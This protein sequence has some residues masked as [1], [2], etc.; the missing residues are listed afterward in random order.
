MSARKTGCSFDNQ[1]SAEGEALGLKWERIDFDAKTIRIE[2]QGAL[3]AS[4]YTL[5]RL[6]LTDS[7]SNRCGSMIF[8]A[9][10]SVEN[11]RSCVRKHYSRHLRSPNR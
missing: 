6:K 5:S 8:A 2:E 3:T 4:G 11:A 10:Y 7:I 9:A 1:T